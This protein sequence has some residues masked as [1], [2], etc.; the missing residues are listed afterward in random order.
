MTSGFLDNGVTAHRGNSCAFPENTMR[1]F[2][3]AIGVGADWAE[4]DVHRTK[5]DQLV[6]IH[7]ADTRRV[8]DT[9]LAVAD[10]TY[11]DL[12]QVDVAHQF[13]SAKRLS[14]EE[15][16]SASAPLLSDVLR[17]FKSQTKTRV[18]IQPKAW[19]VDEVVRM[20]REMD[21]VAWVG[22]NDGDLAKM[23]RVKELDPAIPV[24]WDRGPGADVAHDVE[25][26]KEAG[27]ESMVLHHSLVTRENISRIHQA[28][29]EAGAWTVNDAEEMEALLDMG[30]DRIYT[31]CPERL[32]Q[33][34]DA[35]AESRP[36]CG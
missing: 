9:A 25:A 16:P 2:E 23:R 3:S 1:A 6:V 36:G 13:R 30:L 17:L 34:R 31:D 35:R 12:R 5:D 21:A 27:F 4:L 7:D 29:L 15:C 14:L 33:I 24:F 22:F 19:C 32:L 18:S 20:I 8:G 11:E 28:G 26:A 10:A